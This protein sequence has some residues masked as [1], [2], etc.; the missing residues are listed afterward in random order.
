MPTGLNTSRVVN[1]QL[2]IAPQAAP[3]RNF[4]A[5][6]FLGSSNVI[7]V[8]ERIREFDGLDSVA[9]TFGVN[10]AEYAAFVPFF[11]QTPQPQIGYAGRW[12]QFDTSGVLHG[13]ILL[14][15]QQLITNFQKVTAGAFFVLVDGVPYSL[16]GLNLSTATNLNGVASIIQAA[17]QAA[18][19]AS[20]R[21]LWGSIN[22]RF[23]IISGTTGVTSSLSYGQAPTA[24][25]AIPFSALPAAGSSLNLG[26]TALTFVTG[27]A[28]VN[29]VAINSTA[30]ALTLAA[31]AQ[32]I[33]TSTDPNVSKFTAFASG[34]TLYL[35]SDVSGAAGNALTVSASTTPAS[36][37]TVPSATLSGGSGTDISVLLGFSVLP[38]G[39]GL[40][41]ADP[42]VPGVAA[43]SYLNAVQ[44]LA[45]M[46]SDW[47][48][49]TAATAVPPTQA[50]IL[51]VSAFVEGSTVTRIH[52]VTTQNTA[53]IDA[54]RSDDVSS[55]LMAL[56]YNR[57]LSQFSSGNPFAV[58]SLLGR[59]ATVNFTGVNTTLTLKFKQE[60]G[61]AAESL[62][63]NQ[64]DALEAK[65][66]N[67]F[68][69][70]DNS[71]AILEQGVM[72]GGYYI[73]ERHG[74]DAAQNDIQT[75][76]YN[77][78]YQ[79]PTKVPHDDDGQNLLIAQCYASMQRYITNGFIAP[80]IWTGPSF[81]TLNTGDKMQT[82]VYFYS[83]SFD[84]QSAADNAKRKA[85][86]IQGAIKL[87]GAI[88][89]VDLSIFASR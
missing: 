78:F 55:V 49:I 14:P 25:E 33:N 21:V 71:T 63:A 47:Y 77:V 88:H 42:P 56:N 79:S 66:C 16:T 73:D 6:L 82:G 45:N 83:Q 36:N 85:M 5:M 61:V 43:E 12:A 11:S 15:V 13:A 59:M 31:A 51:A 72:A 76:L 41:N 29:Q 32:A 87:A 38:T 3:T 8:V 48:G 39:P 57:T 4:G 37:A 62:F 27:A 86:P 40:D 9:A 65:N 17:L 69:K 44:T 46:S 70:Y 26:G 24:S 54:T 30:T 28:G 67:V 20:A 81:G 19:A 80:G 89:S 53:V 35:W 58:A 52:A 34:T 18:G 75:D 7:D 84:F 22:Q 64:A 23:D 60:P 74:L 50:D 10:S 68:V 2:T 1:A